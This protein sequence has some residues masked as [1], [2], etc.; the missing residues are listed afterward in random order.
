M[1]F[2]HAISLEVSD[3]TV[4]GKTSEFCGQVPTEALLLILKELTI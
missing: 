2:E 3:D 1:L 4:Y